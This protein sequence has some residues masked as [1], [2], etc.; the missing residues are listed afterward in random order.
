MEFLLNY[1]INSETAEFQSLNVLNSIVDIIT[2]AK[3]MKK[4]RT[5]NFSSIKISL[6]WFLEKWGNFEYASSYYSIL[7]VQEHFA[8]PSPT[9]ESSW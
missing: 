9:T 1:S 6:G 3:V 4:P 7:I 2:V 5:Y 8:I